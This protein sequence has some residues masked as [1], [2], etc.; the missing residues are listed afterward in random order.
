MLPGCVLY[1]FVYAS[2]C[3]CVCF[4]KCWWMHLYLH[5][6]VFVYEYK[7]A[8]MCYC[9]YSSSVCSS[10]CVILCASVFGFLYVF[11][12][13]FIC[14]CDSVCECVKIDG[15]NIE[16]NK[17]YC[18]IVFT[19]EGEL[20]WQLQLRKMFVY[21]FTFAL[22]T[23]SSSFSLKVFIRFL[24]RKLLKHTWSLFMNLS[25]PCIRI[26]PFIIY[27]FLV[28]LSKLG[29]STFV[30]RRKTCIDYQW[31]SFTHTCL[32]SIHKTILYFSILNLKYLCRTI[33][34]LFVL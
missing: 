8:S 5:L 12:Y 23:C 30:L 31:M 20:V 24:F 9:V 22:K 28:K 21:F 16:L 26:G 14:V 4:Y 3:V 13:M 11:F 29:W 17:S 25:I 1:V 34:V 32:F 7:C 18:E 27:Y 33:H 15:A 19:N 2:L 6:C 10:L